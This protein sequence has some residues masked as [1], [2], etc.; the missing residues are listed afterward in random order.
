MIRHEVVLLR[1]D[2][3]VLCR[4]VVL[5]H[6]DIVVLCHEVVLLHHDVVVLRHEVVLLHHEVVVLLHVLCHEVVFYFIIIKL[7]VMVHH[8]WLIKIDSIVTCHIVV[9]KEMEEIAFS[10]KE[11]NSC[12]TARITVSCYRS[13]Q[14]GKSSPLHT[15]NYFMAIFYH[16]WSTENVLETVCCLVKA[17]R[18]AADEIYATGYQAPVLSLVYLEDLDTNYIHCKK[19]FVISTNQLV[20]SIACKFSLFTPYCSIR[21]LE[22]KP[23]FN[24]NL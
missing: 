3:V 7:V 22:G 14:N 13:R 5:L 18:D 9:I 2:V 24:F 6:H 11:G 15:L 16:N 17:I 1:H 4:E 10:I 8:R 12:F 20:T 19:S 23:V 21:L